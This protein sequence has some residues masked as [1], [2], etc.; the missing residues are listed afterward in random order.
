[1]ERRVGTVAS[2]EASGFF[3]QVGMIAIPA[4]NVA[5]AAQ[6]LLVI[7]FNMTEK[8]IWKDY[9][10]YFHIIIIPI[11][12]AM[13]VVPIPFYLYNPWY[14][15]C[16]VTQSGW[17]SDGVYER[18]TVQ[19]AKNFRIVTLLWIFACGIAVSVTMVCIYVA[20]RRT[21]TT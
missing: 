21:L 9:E 11:A 16:S 6:Y 18:G 14:F 1:M 20:V 5:L 7:Q 15:Y 3:I 13:A 19:F 10:R 2:C 17:I 8:R 4:Y 12:F